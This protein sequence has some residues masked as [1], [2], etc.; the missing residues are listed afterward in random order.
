MGPTQPLNLE[1]VTITAAVNKFSLY[2]HL[3]SRS[4]K[5][6]KVPRFIFNHPKNTDKHLNKVFISPS[7]RLIT[8]YLGQGI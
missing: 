1:K 4:S 6:L 7:S 3:L 5:V 8:S 2:L